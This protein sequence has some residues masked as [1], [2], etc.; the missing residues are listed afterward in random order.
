[1]LVLKWF[2]TRKVW[3][4]YIMMKKMIVSVGAAM[5]ALVL[6]GCGPSEEVVAQ[7]ESA[8]AHFTYE[9]LDYAAVCEPAGFMPLDE[10]VERHDEVL[11][12]VERNAELARTVDTTLTTHNSG[13]SIDARIVAHILIPCSLGATI[14]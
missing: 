14:R 1:M 6:S 9:R 13:Q 8:V 3:Y 11:A 4:P 7:G 10:L 5:A 12:A 2:R